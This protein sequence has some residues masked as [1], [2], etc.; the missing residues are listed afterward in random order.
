MD[1]EKLCNNHADLIQHMQNQGYSHNYV[2]G[3]KTEINWLLQSKEKE[4]IQTY[5][6][7]CR[8]RESR[9]KSPDMQGWYRVAYGILKRFDIYNEYP[10]RRKKESLIKKGAY[11][12]LNES[13]KEVIDLYKEADR[14]RGLKE[15]TIYGNASGAS[16]FLLAMQ[17]KGR[18]TLEDITEEDA[19][20]FF[21]DDSGIAA[22]SSSYKKEIA[23]VL[24]ADIGTYT[25]AARHILAYLP[26]IRP[27]R[28]NIPYLTPEEA[29]SIHEVLED[30]DSPLSLR[31]RA[32][33]LLLFFTGIRGCDISQ[34]KFSDIDWENE[35]IRLIQQKTSGSLILPL[36]ATIGNAIYDY[37]ISERPNSRDTH[38]FLSSMKP[39][40]PLK[41]KAMWYISSKLYESA[42]I[43]KNPGDRRGTHLFRYNLATSFSGKGIARPVISDMLGHADP[44]SLDYYLF[45]DM[46][47][48]RECA[49]DITDFPVREEVF[50]V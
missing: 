24:K 22:L 41:P 31:D 34:M 46:A 21:T 38:V 14:K 19:M 23:A 42:D 43:R 7:A 9:T 49:L 13:F 5:E 20:S 4:K 28:K 50:H 29:D 33:G 8:I 11:P 39:H 16:G 2:R 37:V 47:H 15:C 35:E 25:E 18:S 44:N 1:I 26:T 36:T 10:D 40:D 30:K 6:E 17:N 3:L 48:L 32:I 27:K 45:A 12:K